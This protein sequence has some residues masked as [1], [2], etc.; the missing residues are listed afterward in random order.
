MDIRFRPLRAV[1]FVVF[2]LG[3]LAFT[4]LLV[5]RVDF[6]G[7]TSVIVRFPSVGTIQA[8][9]PVRQSGV[10]VGSVAR[11]TLATDARGK[12]DVELSLY[13]GLTIRTSD[14]IAIVTGG[15]LGDQYI[16]IQAG[17]A[18]APLVGPGDTIEGDGGLDLKL[19]VDGGGMV[20][21]DL[22]RTTKAIAR[23]LEAHEDDLDRILHQA[24]LALT[25]AASAAQRADRL[26][27]K[28]EASFDPAMADFQA[29]LRTLKQTATGLETL[30]DDLGAPGAVADL[31]ASPTTGQRVA[32]TLADLQAATRSLKTVAGALEEALR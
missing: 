2:C 15:L 19:L 8:G 28:A 17:S 22:G 1:I 13:R 7:S 14:R 29:T 10:K 32:E 6:G 16:D 23:F 12:V 24:D 9:S 20:I 11:V 25:G 4:Y 21:E 5:F 31:L 30:V 26:L 3:I 27:E 18:D